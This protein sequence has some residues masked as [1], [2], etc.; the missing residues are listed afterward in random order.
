MP[1]SPLSYRSL[2]WIDSTNPG[3]S[4]LLYHPQ[5]LVVIEN[6]TDCFS[7]LALALVEAVM[8]A[9]TLLIPAKLDGNLS[10]AT[11]AHV[12]GQQVVT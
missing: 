7:C 5:I 8:N 1:L 11:I 4:D 6:L 9:T 2:S 12:F 10:G 3:L